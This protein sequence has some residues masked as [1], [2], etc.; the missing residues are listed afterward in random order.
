MVGVGQV[1]AACWVEVALQFAADRRDGTT[2]FCGDEP[3]A[4]ADPMQIGDPG[5]V[6]F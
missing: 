1:P 6:L 5:A 4:V 3:H 2:Q